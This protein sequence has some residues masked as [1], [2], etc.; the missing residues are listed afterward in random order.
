MLTGY[1][2]AEA[3]SED[4]AEN[5]MQRV[6]EGHFPELLTGHSREVDVRVYR[7]L[8]SLSGH[9]RELD[10]KVHGYFAK[11]LSAENV[12]DCVRHGPSVSA[13]LECVLEP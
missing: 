2:S 3:L 12:L 6:S 1:K 7:H 11:L 13:V 10:G 4:G 5:W 8:R 9:L